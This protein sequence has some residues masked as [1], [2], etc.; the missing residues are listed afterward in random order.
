VTKRV[1]IR[2]QGW[3]E[4]RSPFANSIGDPARPA[5]VLSNNPDDAGGLAK[6]R[7]LELRRL[8]STIEF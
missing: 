7:D 4:W 8:L 5:L 2:L 6:A 1:A 3:I